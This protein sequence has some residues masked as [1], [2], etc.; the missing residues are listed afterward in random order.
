[1]IFYIKN[2]IMPYII[3]KKG[4]IFKIKN[5]STGK[6]HKNNF[7]TRENAEIQR[8]NRI[9]FEKLIEKQIRRNK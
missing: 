8:K 7:K 5:T 6:V 1:M 9:R 3:V 2:N 4:N